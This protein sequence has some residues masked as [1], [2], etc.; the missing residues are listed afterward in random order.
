M[1]I[2]LYHVNAFSNAPCGGNP[3]AV[4]LLD[5][6]LDDSLLL[7]VAAENA[8]SATAFLVG[9]ANGYEIRWFTP[10]CEV[11]LCG[12]ATFASGYIVLHLL[13]PELNSVSFQTKHRGAVSVRKDG[14]FLLMDFPEVSTRRC[15]CEPPELRGALGI[16]TQAHAVLQG[17]NSF[18]A[19]F[20]DEDVI[21]NIQP[22]FER[23]EKLHPNVVMVTAPGEQVDFVSRYFAPGYGIPEDP[24]TGS[25]HC[26]LAPY[27]A[28]RLGK[29]QLHAR[30]LSERGGELWCE[31]SGDRVLLR[32]A[33]VLTFKGQ[34]HF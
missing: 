32:G 20:E 22:N 6:W 30:Q 18:I 25:A 10:K 21:R 5:S 33:T 8:V 31:I 1:H 2:P 3:A 9:Q 26:A 17:D 16:D 11:R 29:K 28:E 23:L 27:W 24:V 4:C 12:H 34:L 15:T 14:D 7:K 13:Y 19:V